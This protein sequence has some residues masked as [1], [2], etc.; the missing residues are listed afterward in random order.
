VVSITESRRQHLP[1]TSLLSRRDLDTQVSGDCR[2][3]ATIEGGEA[4]LIKE[5]KDPLSNLCCFFCKRPLPAIIVPLSLLFVVFVN[6]LAL[7][8]SAGTRFPLTRVPMRI[9]RGEQTGS[10]GSSFK[11]TLAIALRRDRT[12]FHW[13]R[14][15]VRSAINGNGN[16]NCSHGADQSLSGKKI[17]FHIE[18]ESVALN[19][20][21]P[22]YAGS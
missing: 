9:T 12:K 1:R 5:H 7:V 21:K 13:A 22:R 18:D 4:R 19:R 20:A 10:S 14:E 15:A 3:R 17:S 11:P 2:T 16:G 8:I 6:E